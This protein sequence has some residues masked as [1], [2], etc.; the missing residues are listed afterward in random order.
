MRFRKP[1]A[2][3]ENVFKHMLEDGFSPAHALRNFM[4]H[5]EFLP[6]TLYLNSITD[7]TKCPDY[8]WVHHFYGK[9]FK[10]KPK[11]INNLQNI[12]NVVK[13]IENVNQEYC[14]QICRFEKLENNHF[15]VSIIT[16][17]MKRALENKNSSEVI[18][19]DSIGNTNKFGLKIYVLFSEW[20]NMKI[21]LGIII[22]TQETLF[23]IEKG[24]RLFSLMTDENSFGGRGEEG[25]ISIMTD[26]VKT[27]MK[28]LKLVFPKSSLFWSTFHFLKTIYN[29]LLNSKYHINKEDISYLYSAIKKLVYSITEENLEVNYKNIIQLFSHNLHLINYLKNLYNKKN[30]WALCYRTSF[31]RNVPSC[32]SSV[33]REMQVLKEQMLHLLKTQSPCDLIQY[34]IEEYDSFYKKKLM[35]NYVD[36]NHSYFTNRFI[37]KIEGKHYICG[38]FL[39]AKTLYYVYNKLKKTKYIVNTDIGSCTCYIGVTGNFCKHQRL[40]IG[41]LSTNQDQ[42]YPFIIEFKI[43]LY[44]IAT[45]NNETSLNFFHSLQNVNAMETDT[46]YAMEVI[47][48]SDDTSDSSYMDEIEQNLDNHIV[49]EIL[50]EVKDEIDIEK[51]NYAKTDLIK[52]LKNYFHALIM[53]LR[54]D[55]QYYEK[56]IVSMY[57]ELQKLKE[58]SSSYQLDALYSFNGNYL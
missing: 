26:N 41:F 18:F 29:W 30:K 32:C 46:Q 55:E 15:V 43:D 56:G 22:T 19:I 9:L 42:K 11:S 16:P 45:G 6:S 7:R 48:K 35:D 36:L 57:K 5:L 33:E 13:Y 12:K 54:K 25:P 28:A 8:N 24:L 39:N 37:N 1:S 17:L 50:I 51:L 23:V 3:V 53:K 10:K 58:L 44:Y 47:L 14:T 4:T 20:Y 34:F 27:E 40:L 2:E 52:S 49:E 38:A 31:L 21:P